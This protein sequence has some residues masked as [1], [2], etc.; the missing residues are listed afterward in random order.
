MKNKLHVSILMAILALVAFSCKKDPSVNIETFEITKENINVAAKSAT[1]TG[2][3]SYSGVVDGIEAC[4]SEVES[5]LNVG[6]FPAILN[7]KNFSVEITGLRVGTT[8]SYYYS[9]DYGVS[10]PYLTET[11]TFTTTSE[12]PE[13][14]IV[15][16]LAIDSTTYRVKCE[17]VSGGGQEVTERGI[18]WNTYGDPNI[19][20]ETIQHHTSGLG[21]Y[22]IR[23][24]NLAMGK[25]YYVRAY[26]KNA[27][28]VGL[29]EEVL[30]FVTEAPQGMPVEIELSCNPEQGGTVT[31]GGTY[32]IG[33][34]CTVIA[35][36]NAGYTFVNWTENG[37]QVSSD[38]QYTFA[39]NSGRSLVA[40]FT[41]QAYIITAQVDPEDSGTV[42]GAG[43]YNSGE[44]CTLIAT[45]KTGYGF[46][47]WTKGG[48]TVSTNATYTFTVTSTATYVAH[49]KI[50]SY[51][52]SVSAN[53]SNGGTATGG[54]T[55]NYGQTCT[56][57][58]TPASGYTFT[59]WTDDSDIV[60]TDADYTFTVTSNRTLKANFK[61]N[62]TGGTVPQGAINGLFTIN[63][64]GDQVYFSKGNL[65]Y[66]GSASTPYWKFADNQWDVLGTT[67]GQNS[68][69]PN[70]DRDFFGW[71]TSGYN[72]GAV[73]YRPWS[74][75]QSNTEYYAYG[76][77][78]Y[79]LYDQTGKADWGYNAISNGG[80]TT[81]TWRTLTGGNDG[82]WTYVF[83][84]RSASMVNGVANARYAKAKVVNMYGVILFPDVYLHP[85][86]VA[87][88]VGI[89]QTDNTGWNGNDYSA[90]DFQLMQAAGVVFL[91]AAGARNVASVYG[92]GSD[93]YYWSASYD[94]ISYYIHDYAYCVH[95]GSS[96][97][98]PLDMSN[99]YM[100]RSVRLVCPAEN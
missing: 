78:F 75:S 61:N 70:V 59:N 7:G 99:R 89:N 1:I 94:D 64:S 8:Y 15:E 48:T 56:V 68:T 23:M 82:E 37:N 11:K 53:P 79:N 83:T 30:D 39:V 22:S 57:H 71:G 92:V 34:Q 49:F 40:N 45:P 21:Q 6:T 97:L 98:S 24:E 32:E 77:Y 54:G 43:G 31:G 36:A 3:Y 69:Y 41:K 25:R 20:D 16:M 67:T 95:F 60:S 4:V 47:K 42:T 26:A 58:A 14:K 62:N 66:I 35:V 74:T 86:G 46:E 81:N 52:I 73:C 33:T 100:G 50:K 12:K 18:C 88:P 9:V 65:Q 76:Q 85:T 90:A 17:V 19:D 84:I 10:K 27:T 44:Q 72:H 13:V 28:G 93:G 91:P 80:N 2:V 38:A 87:Q 96:D 51:T 55:V 5:G 63:S 29:S